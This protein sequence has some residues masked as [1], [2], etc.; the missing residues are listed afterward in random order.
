[1]LSRKAKL[2]RDKIRRHKE[3]HVTYDVDG[4]GFMDIFSSIGKAASS[5][6]KTVGPALSTAAKAVGSAAKAAAPHI[7][8]AAKYVGKH[9]DDWAPPLM[10]GAS[11]LI[12]AKMRSKAMDINKE[13]EKLLQSRATERLTLDNPKD[14]LSQDEINRLLHELSGASGTE[15]ALRAAQGHGLDKQ[16]KRT[17]AK[18]KKGKGAHVTKGFIPN[19]AGLYLPGTT[20]A[21]ASSSTMQGLYQT[22]QGNGLEQVT[23]SQPCYMRPGIIKF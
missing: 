22:V 5:A 2:K 1:M 13:A 3:K 14:E 8:T 23:Q 11:Q 17:K 18:P 9:A 12:S 15:R 16:S 20:N 21:P 6:A 10:N 7:A 19:A 4:E